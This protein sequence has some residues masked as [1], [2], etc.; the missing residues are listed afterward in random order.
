MESTTESPAPTTDHARLVRDPDDRVVAGVAGALARYVGVEP[1]FVRIAFVIATVLGGFGVLVYIG[2][3]LAIP[4]TTEN[5]NADRR[6][7]GFWVGVAV[8]VVGAL[9]FL[10]NF[11]TPDSEL[12][13]AALLIGI[14]VA[15]WRRPADTKLSGGSPGADP[16]S[17]PLPTGID[18]PSEPAAHRRWT[19]PPRWS[20]DRR[21]PP[22]PS[23]L[24]R[25]T[26]A[27]TMLVA[28]TLLAF[29]RSG[30]DVD[31]VDVAAAVLVTIGAGLVVGAFYGR[32]RW[33]VLPAVLLAGPVTGLATLDR[34]GL[35][36]FHS[37]G[38]D[39][40]LVTDVDDLRPVYRLGT[41]EMVLDLGLLDVEGRTVAVRADVAIGSLQVRVPSGVDVVV[42]AAAGLGEVEL[43][44]DDDDGRAVTA[45]A[46][47]DGAEGAGRIELD[48]EV[49]MGEVTV[50]EARTEA[51]IVLPPFPSVPDI[52]LFPG[53]D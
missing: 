36:P 14:G 3:W 2:C 35:D 49:G 52:P 41:G 48:L 23:I 53:D 34:M 19:P 20:R 29:D 22:P 46:S 31:A 25:V 50:R 32:A 38:D 27:A 44:G 43:F 12:A 30:T 9:V 37:V 11:D 39:D 5:T 10:D 26:L 7:F 51:P 17:H 15:L 45:S 13:F 24:G 33:L 6:G 1:T 21:P 16:R 40:Y 42:E 18:R 47:L 4:S 28:A 8:V